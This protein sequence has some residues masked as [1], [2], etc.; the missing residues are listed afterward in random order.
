MTSD[1][2]RVQPTALVGLLK[3]ALAAGSWGTWSI[4][5]RP[6]GL[7]AQVTAPL[8][9]VMIG[10]FTLPLICVFPSPAQWDKRTWQ[11]LAANIL[12]DA[13]NLTAFFLAMSCTTVAVAV[14]THYLAPVLVA[15][16]APFVDRQRVA[17]A[18]PAAL[19]A[20]TGLTL[21]LAP[22]RTLTADPNLLLGAGLGTLSAFA[23]AGNV[24]VIRR[25]AER[26]G[27]PRAQAYHS[28][29]AAVLI[30]P[31]LLLVR[32]DPHL[33][34]F[35]IGLLALGALVPGSLAGIAFVSGLRVIGAARA[36]VLAYLE[37]LVAVAV[38]WL[39]WHEHLDA[40]ALVGGALV[41]TG[42]VLVA[43]TSPSRAS[44]RV[45]SAGR[46]PR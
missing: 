7:P 23:Y 2:T 26:I 29:F 10:V 1:P 25:L 16:L 22:W 6:G 40:L 46:Y 20:V 18:L 24:F 27:A 8:T 37:P 36:S 43:R 14:L 15:L 32:G 5:L 13:V 33:T 9:F 35:A 28:L 30:S 11:L 12:L 21:V 39:C 31:L 45:E 3:V 38:G 4:F 41:L 42:G 17:V 19:L 34:P 44:D